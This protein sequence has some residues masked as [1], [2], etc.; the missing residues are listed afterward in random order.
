M[1]EIAL[2]ELQEIELNILCEFDRLCEANSLKYGITSGTLLGA[3]RHGGFIPWDDDI[4]IVMPREDYIKFIELFSKQAKEKFYLATPYNN[5]EYIYEYIKM[6]DLSTRMLEMPTTKKIDT[7]VY[8]DIFPVDGF[9]VN[10]I[11]QRIHFCHVKTYQFLFALFKRAKYK[12]SEDNCKYRF[13]WKGIDFINRLLPPYYIIHKL[14]RVSQRYPYK[15][16][17]YAGVA[18]GQWMKEVLK[19]EEYYLDGEILFENRRFHTYKNP[20]VYLSS[21]YGDYMKIPPIEKRI[22]HDNIAWKID[23]QKR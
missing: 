11:C 1:R 21:L 23:D 5:E 9:P 3:V 16:S 14:D 17:F 8:I 19:K 4:D 22:V 6:M 7:H 2:R 13:M 20:D 18:T 15:S 10:K 12:I